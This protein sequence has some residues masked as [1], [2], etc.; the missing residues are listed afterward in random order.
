METPLDYSVIETKEELLSALK[1]TLDSTPISVLQEAFIKSL[2]E[3]KTY[4]GITLLE[5]LGCGE[6][7]GS[8][9]VWNK[10]SNGISKITTEFFEKL[11]KGEIQ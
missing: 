9:D 3:P 5:K 1:R 6:L 2:L 4:A 11:A 7:R 8:Y 10:N